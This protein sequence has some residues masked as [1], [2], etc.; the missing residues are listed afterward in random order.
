MPTEATTASLEAL[1]LVD[2]AEALRLRGREVEAI[3][4]LR[5]AVRVDSAFGLGWGK[6]SA[7]LSN[8]GDIAGMMDASRRAYES[9]DGVSNRERLYIVGRYHLEVTGELFKAVDD[10]TEWRAA[11]PRDVAPVTYLSSST[12]GSA[13]SK[14][15]STPGAR[16]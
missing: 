12:T 9:R 16:R 8:Q 6:L 11:Y 5:S 1:R 15:P 14:K 7:A 2:Q 3:P 10:F 4:L 13:R